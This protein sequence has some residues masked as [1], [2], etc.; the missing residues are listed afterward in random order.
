MAFTS[1]MTN[2]KLQEDLFR[3]AEI[4][5]LRLFGHEMGSEMRKFIGNLSWSFFGGIIASGIMFVV[6]ILAGRWLGPEE[7][8]KYNALLSFATILSTVYLFGMDISSV[9]YLSDKRHSASLKKIFTTSFLFVIFIQ[10]I[11]TLLL[12][13]WYRFF[14][15]SN[16]NFISETFLLLGIFLAIMISLKSLFNGFLRAFHKYR[17]QSVYRIFDAASVA[18]VFII[19]VL[20]FGRRIAASYV[21]SF[22]VGGVIFIG[23]SV[24][25]LRGN[26]SVF[27]FSLLKKIFSEYNRHVLILSLIGMVVASDKLIIGKFLGFRELGYYSAYYAA[28]HLFI[29]ELGGIFMNVFWPSVIKNVGSMSE[30]VRKTMRLFVHFSPIWIALIGASVF[31]LISFFGSEYPLRYDYLFLF[32]VNAFLG[33]LFSIFTGFLNVG[34]IRRGII[35]F[36]SFV[37]VS[38]MSLMFS[39]NIVTY[40]FV[41]ILFQAVLI[42]HMKSFLLKLDK[43]LI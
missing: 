43:A 36:G 18:A 13:L 19:V 33:F 2:V 35:V 3:L 21:Y 30:I 10:G 27:D 41:Q 7:Y 23:F 40:L 37:F 16:E 42:W 5:H 12:L 20:F 22:M 32:S 29:A 14:S 8:G 28:S 15:F 39:R 6:A 26:F 11:T 31:V 1:P 38:L 24:W 9:R 17:Q 4:V 34:H 25:I